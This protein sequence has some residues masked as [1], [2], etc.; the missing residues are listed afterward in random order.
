[1]KAVRGNKVYT[2]TDAEKESYKKLGY[3]IMDD[4]GKVIENGIGKTVSYDKYKELEEENIALRKENQDFKINSMT[5]EQLKSY[6]MERNI[7]LADATTKDA[8][9]EKIKA[10]NQDVI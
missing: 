3:D 1:M 6:A 2:I 8:I 9:L 10:V 5:V 7:D 4:D